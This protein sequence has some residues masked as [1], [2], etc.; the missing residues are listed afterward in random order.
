MCHLPSTTDWKLLMGRAALSFTR[1]SLSRKKEVS[2]RSEESFTTALTCTEGLCE[3]AAGPVGVCQGGAQPQGLKHQGCPSLRTCCQPS[4][5][6][7]AMQGPGELQLLPAWTPS[8]EVHLDSTPARRQAAL[9]SAAALAC[10]GGI[11]YAQR[12][13]APESTAHH[14]IGWMRLLG[15]VDVDV[16]GGKGVRRGQGCARG[17]GRDGQDVA[18]QCPGVPCCAGLEPEVDGPRSAAGCTAQ[19]VMACS[20]MSLLVCCSKN[21]ERCSH[22]RALGSATPRPAGSCCR[23]GCCR[24]SGQLPTCAISAGSGCWLRLHWGCLSTKLLVGLTLSRSW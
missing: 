9:G 1:P 5:R 23:T 13:C 16:V 3:N 21:G 15:Q 4:Q 11:C 7:N 20:G 18:K 6:H 19:C 10:C 14:A 22:Q 8:A 17:V 12:L 2:P 24:T